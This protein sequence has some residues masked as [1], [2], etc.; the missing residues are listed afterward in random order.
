MLWMRQCTSHWSIHS[1]SVD[2]STHRTLSLLGDE[3]IIDNGTN[4]LSTSQP[5]LN[6]IYL[7]N[8]MCCVFLVILLMLCNS[9]NPVSMVVDGF[10]AYLAL[11][12]LQSPWWH[13]PASTYQECLR[14]MISSLYFS[15]TYIP[16]P[17]RQDI[18]CSPFIPNIHGSGTHCTK[19][20]WAHNPNLEKIWNAL[21]WKII[22]KSGHKFAHVTTAMLSWR[23]NFRPDWIIWIIFKD[24]INFTR[25]QLRA[26]KPFMR[27]VR[28]GVP[29][30]IYGGL[31]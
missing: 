26:H 15:T 19:S 21:T 3:P 17:L 8:V 2:T 29:G 10:G 30:Y 18:L 23:A 4:M 6:M 31:A 5:T 24:K 1:Y 27:W 16:S 11:R 12:H 7:M 28:G 22:I 9:Y 13:R 14:V 25:F 20:L